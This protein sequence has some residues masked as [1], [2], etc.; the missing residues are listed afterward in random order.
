MQCC[1][2]R[3]SDLFSGAEAA[4]HARGPLHFMA[5]CQLL[6]AQVAWEA[7]SAAG[8]AQPPAA[9]MLA[10]HTFHT[11]LMAMLSSMLIMQTRNEAQHRPCHGRAGG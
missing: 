11:Y 8:K 7:V 10:W 1:A 4:Q 5:I 9:T 6:V 3:V 2:S